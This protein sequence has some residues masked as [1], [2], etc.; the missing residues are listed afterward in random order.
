MKNLKNYKGGNMNDKKINYS[1]FISEDSRCYYEPI[2]LTIS[3]KIS[4]ALM[5]AINLKYSI[6]LWK[7]ISNNYKLS[8]NNDYKLEIKKGFKTWDE[9]KNSIEEAI[10]ILYKYV[11]SVN[12]F[13]LNVAKE[14]LNK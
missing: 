3:S 13:E 10:T 8:L 14:L 7:C 9:A 1:I 2:K 12:E 11:D 6:D 4:P 5:K